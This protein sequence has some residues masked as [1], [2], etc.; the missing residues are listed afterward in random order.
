MVK[1]FLFERRS[2]LL[3]CENENEHEMRQEDRKDRK[4]EVV[5]WNTGG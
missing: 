5:R 1:K 2:C 3:K 4:G